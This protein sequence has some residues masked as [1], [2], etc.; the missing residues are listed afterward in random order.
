MDE[1]LFANL[2]PLYL[3]MNTDFKSMTFKKLMNE[4]KNAALLV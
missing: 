3:I 2:L 4:L 1:R